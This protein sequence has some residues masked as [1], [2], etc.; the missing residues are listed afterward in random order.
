MGILGVDISGG[1]GGGVCQEWVC[2]VYRIL[3]ECLLVFNGFTLVQMDR[4][5]N[6]TMSCVSGMLQQ[7]LNVTPL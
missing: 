1:G 2:Q 7:H 6:P 3:L 4:R 5:V